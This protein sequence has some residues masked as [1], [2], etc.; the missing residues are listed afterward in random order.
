MKKFFI[1]A[2]TF[3]LICSV[4]P[5]NAYVDYKENFIS[6]EVGIGREVR[7]HGQVVGCNV[8]VERY[9]SRAIF[10]VRTGY[11]IKNDDINAFFTPAIYLRFQEFALGY[12]LRW[13]EGREYLGFPL[14]VNTKAGPVNLFSEASFYGLTGNIRCDFES[15]ISPA[16][17]K[18]WYPELCITA[19]A[20]HDPKPG[21]EEKG[22]AV[23][24]SL[25]YTPD[26]YGDFL[27]SIERRYLNMEQE[28][29]TL[30]FLGIKFP[31]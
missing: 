16:W 29:D 17:E 2:V 20:N 13:N 21:E 22:C 18:K 26:N 30:V 19:F 10:S 15:R 8:W 6:E 12:K 11:D 25:G 4:I 1:F 5:A 24:A 14:R 23:R 28:G 27:L 3:I 31:W 7:D 9:V